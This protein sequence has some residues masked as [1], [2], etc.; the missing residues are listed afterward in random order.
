ME[1][2]RYRRLADRPVE[3]MH[4]HFEQHSY[5]MHSH[6][7][8]SF[9][10]TELGAQTFGCR[11]SRRTSAAGMVMAFNPDEP[12]DGHA[13]TEHGFTYR[14]IHIGPSLVTDVLSDQAGRSAGMPLFTEPVLHDPV[15]ARAL[16]RLYNSLSDEA[17]A[18]AKDEALAET[19]AAL[20]RR[21][22]MSAPVPV[23][24]PLA[25]VRRARELLDAEYLSA[26]GAED[27]ATAAG[28]SRFALYRAFKATY[29]MSP[30]D[31]QRLLRLRAARRLIASGTAPAEAAVRSGF[32][33]QAHLTR[34]FRRYY[35]ITPGTYQRA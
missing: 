19:V 28:C 6:D 18:L 13:E 2:V 32:A 9:G 11:G 5:H 17:S 25:N 31:Y 8:Y 1:W 34:W 14:I 10:L 7:T 16:D 20:V 26:V 27:L 23:V 30:S 12:H 35:G 21:A 33:D 29:G 4:A 15:L 22:A 24:Q 3:A